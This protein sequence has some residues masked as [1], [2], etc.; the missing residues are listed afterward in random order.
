MTF[1]TFVRR[2]GG[3][4]FLVHFVGY[5]F[6]ILG[7]F[8]VIVVERVLQLFE[9]RFFDE[10]FGGRFL[11]FR[12][13]FRLSLRL[14]VLGFGKLFSEGRYFIVGKACTVVHMGFGRF[15][16]LR[17]G[18]DIAI[19]KFRRCARLFGCSGCLR[20]FALRGAF[21]RLGFLIGGNFRLCNVWSRV[22]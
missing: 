9:L 6:R 15:R 10:R 21:F 7:I 3:H 4:G 12:Q 5:R 22:L 17:S 13:I 19:T 11:G 1:L 16:Q 20:L 2:F 14:F 18:F 8:L